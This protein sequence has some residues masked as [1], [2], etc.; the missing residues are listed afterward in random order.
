MSCTC[1]VHEELRSEQH[2][3]LVLARALLAH[4][5]LLLL[6]SCIATQLLCIQPGRHL[7]HLKTFFRHPPPHTPSLSLLLMGVSGRVQR[8]RHKGGSGE[9]C[10]MTLPFFLSDMSRVAAELTRSRC[11]E[12]G[13][14][15]VTQVLPEDK[16]PPSMC[17]AHAVCT[18][19]S[20]LSNICVWCWREHC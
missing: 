19:S 2:L 15:K 11:N 4:E 14:A 3:C 10:S 8:L 12:S 17:L 6:S 20:A 9:P 13:T 1:G 16:G 5:L 7:V 18:K